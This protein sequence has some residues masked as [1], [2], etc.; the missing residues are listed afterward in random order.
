M[1]FYFTPKSEKQFEKLNRNA[2]RSICLLVRKLETTEN[3]LLLGKLLKGNLKE[4]WRFRAG[5]Y[6]LICKIENNAIICLYVGNRQNIYKDFN[7]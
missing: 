6:R 5:D 1:I 7:I 3:L 4:F 2:Q